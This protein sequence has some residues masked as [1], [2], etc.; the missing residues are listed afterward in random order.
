[1]ILTLKDIVEVLADVNVL[2]TPRI[3]CCGLTEV[4]VCDNYRLEGNIWI[5][6][7]KRRDCR[8]RTV[9]HEIYHALAEKKGLLN[10]EEQAYKCERE[11]YKYIKENDRTR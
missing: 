2:Q 6:S 11:T 5:N 9:I 8:E 3:N 7:D 10:T 1:M 4:G